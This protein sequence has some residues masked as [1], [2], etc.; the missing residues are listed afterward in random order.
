MTDWK[1]LSSE[2]VY[3]TPW[4]KIHRDEVLNHTGKHLTYSFV[5]LQHPSAFIVPVNAESKIL[6][7]RSYRYPIKKTVW[8]IPAGHSDGQNLLEAAER[9]LLEET[10]LTS[11]DWTDMGMQYQ[12]IGI[13]KIPCAM[14][15][16]RNVRTAPDK[17]DEAE[18]I[19]D[20]MEQRFFDVEEIDAMVK[21]GDIYDTPVIVAIY[22]AKLY[23]LQK[24]GQ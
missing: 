16:A 22:L 2:I 14:F 3:E 21:Q 19:E 20:I 18:D 12:A 9:E 24:E 6:L 7:Q 4:F 5:E 11:T 23:G 13:G 1:T 17:T 10:G 8:E 15:L